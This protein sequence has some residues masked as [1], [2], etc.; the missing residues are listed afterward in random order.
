MQIVQCPQCRQSVPGSAVRCQF[1]GAVLGGGPEAPTPRAMAG[2]TIISGKGARNRDFT[3]WQDKAYRVCCFFLLFMG[4]ILILQ[5]MNVIETKESARTYIG[6]QGAIQAFFALMLLWEQTWAQFVMK[7]YLILG[8]LGSVL[9]IP[10]TLL[11]F[12][13]R[14]AAGAALLLGTLFQLALQGLL[15]YLIITSGDA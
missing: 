7:W 5:G 12:S 11:M 13:I 14:P 3:T 2:V 4:G 15:L 6:V 1:C 8:V 10:M 9:S